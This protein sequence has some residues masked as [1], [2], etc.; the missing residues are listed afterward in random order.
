MIVAEGSSCQAK[1]WRNREITW[2]EFLDKLRISHRTSETIEEFRKMSKAE[3]LKVKDVGGFVFGKLKNG[4]RKK[5]FVEARYA[6]AY[7]SDDALPS[8]MGDAKALG[9]TGCV[10]TTHQHTPEKPRLRIIYPT[11]RAMSEEEYE[12]ISRMI[13]KDLGIEQFDRISFRPTQMMFY[14]STSI[15][16]EYIFEE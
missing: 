7:D 1:Q 12:P 14:P 16:G 6:L 11:S 9:F 4:I 5:G 13:A 8:L 2:E 15:D 3:Q 10:N